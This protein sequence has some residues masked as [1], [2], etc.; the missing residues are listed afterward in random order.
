M[1]ARVLMSSSM[2]A[3]R[4]AIMIGICFLDPDPNH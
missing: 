4:F 3:V 2:S 1:L